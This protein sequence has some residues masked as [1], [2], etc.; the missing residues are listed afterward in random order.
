[1]TEHN[2]LRA[3]PLIGEKPYEHKHIIDIGRGK[4]HSRHANQRE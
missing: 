2:V 1:L 3:E 4:Q